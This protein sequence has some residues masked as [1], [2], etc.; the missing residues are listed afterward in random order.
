MLDSKASIEVG[1]ALAIARDQL[2]YL[3]QH[4]GFTIITAQVIA[5]CQVTLNKHFINTEGKKII[6]NLQ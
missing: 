1:K 2:E 6:E 3:Q 4:T 5:N